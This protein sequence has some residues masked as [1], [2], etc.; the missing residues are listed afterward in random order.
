MFKRIS[1]AI[2]ILL[3]MTSLGYCTDNPRLLTYPDS[4][5]MGFMGLDTLS[6]APTLQDGRA[7]DLQN[8]TLT[9]AFDLRQRYGYSL[10]NDTLDDLWLIEPAITGIFN[11]S[12]SD[13]EFWPIVFLGDKVKY[14][15]SGT[16]TD[17]TGWN[18]VNIT[19]GK[20]N[21]WLCDM[22]LD[23]AICTNDVDA[24]LQVTSTPEV[25]TLGFTGLTYPPSAAKAVIW[26]RN[27]LIFGNTVENSVEKPT[28]FR[29]GA[30]GEI[31]ASWDD[32][33]F[34]DISE[35]GGDE[36]IAYAE[37]Y[38]S[39]LVFFKDSIWRVSLVGGDSIFTF[40]KMIEGIG[41]IAKHSVQ[42][43]Q[44]P[45]N[46]LGIVFLDRRK[47]IYLIT[48][49]GIIDIGR[50]IQSSLDSLNATRLQYA[51]GVFDGDRYLLSV[52][53]SGASSNDVVYDYHIR[54]KEWSKHTQIDANALERVEDSSNDF[55]TYAGNYDSFV[56]KLFDSSKKNDI[57]GAT[58]FVDSMGTLLAGDTMTGA[59]VLID[60]GMT[61]GIYTGCVV[62]IVSGTGV[63]QEK[64]VID[65]TSTGLVV[66]SA[67]TTSL[68]TTSQYIMGDIDAYYITK[69]YDFGDAY[70]KKT[71]K[72]IYFWAE[73]A[74]SHNIT[75]DYAEDYGSYIEDFTESLSPA[76][77]AIWG[78][79]IWGSSTWGVLGDTMKRIDMRGT[80][81]TL[82]LKFSNDNL[83]E[84]FH[85]YG[86][87]VLA[88]A[89]DIQ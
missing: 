51:V 59:T 48:G 67:F 77:Q 55:Y 78:T 37:L 33:N 2:V 83:D 30:V 1:S 7:S 87:G 63:G 65:Q 13:G 17:I 4:K 64:V 69:W 71:F 43:V 15:N 27:Y 31:D 38:G 23:Y 82:R 26:F 9:D 39:L 29:W 41:A 34:N 58:G 75:I 46:S 36:I 25:T 85:I 14:D 61:V 44:L 53:S 50:Q 10:V 74:G 88:D 68:D 6:T 32:D 57:D 3:L 80:G 89:L 86:Y 47:R 73:Q 52:S 54:I 70:R 24:P 56:Y 16:W 5:I 66:D 76:D 19:D 60:S 18:V 81:R 22:A 40:S 12:F 49:A 42:N 11:A 20:N 79:G 62:R 72:E 45:D 35:L 21:Q 8:V 28:R 84:T